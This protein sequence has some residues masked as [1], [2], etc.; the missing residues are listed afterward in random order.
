VIIIGAQT[1]GLKTCGIR[2]APNRKVKAVRVLEERLLGRDKNT[3]VLHNFR[4]TRT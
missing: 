4:R 3:D 1:A 2:L